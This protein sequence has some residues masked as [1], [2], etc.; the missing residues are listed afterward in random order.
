MGN[1]TYLTLIASHVLSLIL[2]FLQ[3]NPQEFA[4][5][6]PKDCAEAKES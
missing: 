2:E 1:Y 6:E 3:P 5:A 4:Q